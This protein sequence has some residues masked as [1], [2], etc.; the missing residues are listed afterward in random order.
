MNK[1][2]AV[3]TAL[4]VAAALIVVAVVVIATPQSPGAPVQQWGSAAGRPHR[5]PASK[6]IGALVNDQVVPAGTAASRSAPEAAARSEVRPPKGAVP[7]AS[8]PPKVRLGAAQARDQARSLGPA[9][10]S[11]SPGYNP[12]SSR[13]VEDQTSADRVVYQN[14]DGTRTALFFDA[15]VNYRLPAG[16]WASVNTSLV[17]ARA[18]ASPSPLLPPVKP[19]LLS[20]SPAPSGAPSAAH[21]PGSASGDAVSASAADEVDANLGTTD[22]S[23]TD[24]TLGAAGPLAGS[25]E[26]AASFNGT[27]SYVSLPSDL[28]IDQDYVSVGVWFKAA[29]STASGVLFGYQADALSNSSGPSAAHVPALY[30]GGNGELYGE[31]WNGAVEPMHSSVN[32]DDGNWHYAVLTASG[33]SQSLWLDGTEVGTLTGQISPDGM[34]VDTAGSGF[35]KGWPEDY[36]TEGPSLLDTSIGW[37]DGSVAQLAVYPRSLGQPAIDQQYA[38]AT[39]ASAELTQVSL[40]SGQVYQQAGYNPDYDR[41][42]S[43]T[44]PNGGQWQI[45]VPLTTGYKESSDTL[46]EATRSVTVVSPAGDDEVYGYDAINGGRLISFTP[47]HGD[48]PETFGYDEA[49][50]ID[51]V[52]DSDGNLV[53]MTNDIHGNALSRTWYPAGPAS[54]AGTS[55]SVSSGAPEGP[56]AAAQSSASWCTQ[57]GAACTTYYSYYY[58]AANPLDPRNDQLTGVADARSASS[59]DTTYLTSYAYNA[60]GELTSSTTPATSDF[61]DG[62]ATTYVYS[63]SSTP[64]YGGSGTI[65]PG[66]LVSETTPGGAVTSY[67]YYA[68]GDLAQVTQPDGAATVY[69]YDAMGRST[70]YFYDADEELIATQ[71]LTTA[72]TGRQTAYS[73][74]GA[75]NLIETDVSSFPVTTA[76]GPGLQTL[77]RE[78][79]PDQYAGEKP[80]FSYDNYR[81]P[82]CDYTRPGRP[83]SMLPSGTP[84]PGESQTL[85][86]W[87]KIIFA[88]GAAGELINELQPILQAIV[89]AI[90]GHR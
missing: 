86:A 32:V 5:V 42:A 77:G 60:S 63:T 66:L 38:L 11:A 53:T 19:S 82:V 1:V 14:A 23:Y 12:R 41:I 49:G 24:V 55:A 20:P 84:F 64:A 81:E 73:Y 88:S 2:V 8:R 52:Q 35:W 69:T 6:T 26:T 90:A 62:R 71:N 70:T 3:S 76:E 48:P 4:V 43:H 10:T 21:A 18:A 29:S 85:T 33:T 79:S 37:F 67:S 15:P 34:T 68:D 31:F 89:R 40:P 74:D 59:A 78:I 39:A 9:A 46:A 50:N 57:T 80:E 17:P 87:Q 61:P 51:Q 27:S 30:V 45:H 83:T 25:A 22:G 65:P 13:V 47:G 56:Q 28:V 16:W 75:G 72:G 54:S 36:I 7:A 58:D 44:D